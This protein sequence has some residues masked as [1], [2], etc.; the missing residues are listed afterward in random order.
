MFSVWS[1]P[2]GS[3]PRTDDRIAVVKTRNKR[4]LDMDS[5]GQRAAGQAIITRKIQVQRTGIEAYPLS[6]YAL[7]YVVNGRKYV[8]Y[9]DTRY[10]IGHDHL[11]YLGMGNHY[12]EDIPEGGQ[13]YEQIVFHYS[14]DMLSEMYSIFSL[15]YG[16]D[17]GDME[18]G[19]DSGMALAHESCS[20]WNMARCFFSGIGQYVAYDVFT[21]CPMVE[22][23]KATELLYIVMSCRECSIRE[24]LLRESNMAAQGFEQIIRQN[25][26]SGLT[27][28][29]LA[30]LCNRTVASF[31]KEFAKHFHESPHKWLLNR[32][33]S[34]SRMLLLST[35]KTIAAIASECK[36]A[37]PSH[38]IKLFKHAY[39]MTPAT[40]RSRRLGKRSV[41]VTESDIQPG[42]DMTA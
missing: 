3:F 5:D 11:F 39:G 30:A 32:R 2:Q 37:N 12:V 34:H 19:A 14:P 38:Y 7:G 41:A 4:V 28:E 25:I 20:A 29:E 22:K 13:P 16:L 27:V 23:L 33:L 21:D 31:K 9:G 24:R 1:G 15:H 42:E 26:F 36:F 40:Y 10:E 18:V 8:Y 17:V 6:R 35:G